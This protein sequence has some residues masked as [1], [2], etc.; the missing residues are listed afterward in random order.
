MYSHTDA[1]T[2]WCDR[3]GLASMHTLQSRVNLAN[4]QARS[5]DLDGATTT[6]RA[7][8]QGWSDR[9]GTHVADNIVA[10]LNLAAVLWDSRNIDEA[11]REHAAALAL[12]NRVLGP[13]HP[14]TRRARRMKRLMR[15]S[16][17]GHDN[18]DDVTDDEVADLIKQ[19]VE[20][21]RGDDE[22]CHAA[23]TRI[24]SS[25]RG[26]RA[27]KHFKKMRCDRIHAIVTI[28]AAFRRHLVRLRQRNA[29][30]G[31]AHV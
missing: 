1:Y 8:L 10:R 17:T 25:F 11:Q 22:E 24:Q 13:S 26:F 12:C 2:A 15:S 3:D 28:Q 4:A 19:L 18:N 30:I 31:R 9:R 20:E 7:V 6:L 16:M 29:E 23:A 21:Y 27:R 5:G 14:V